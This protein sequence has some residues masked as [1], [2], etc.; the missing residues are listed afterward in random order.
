MKVLNLI[1]GFTLGAG[2]DKCF[3]TY[4]KL[5]EVDKDVEVKSFCINLLNL[6]SHIEPLKE[7]GV[8]LIDIKSRSD[9]SWI[10]RLNDLIKEEKPDV[11][12]THGFNGAIMMLLLRML[13]GMKTPVVCSYH[14]AYHAPTM[15][16][17]LVEPIYN[18][19][20]ILIYKTIA[21][22][23]ICVEN[24]SRE[25]LCKKGVRRDKVVTVHNGI[26]EIKRSVPV[27]LSKYVKAGVPTIVT[28]SRITEVKGLPYLLKALKILK[29]KGV[30]FHYF[31]I[32]EGPD[33]EA[34]KKQ[35]AEL[36]L[37]ENITFAGFQSNVPEWLAACDIFALPSLYEYH[38]IAVLEAMRAGKA[39]VA[40]TV[41]GNGESITDGFEGVLVPSKDAKA[42]C[43]GLEKM[44][45]NEDVRHQFGSLARKR[46]EKEFTE[47]AMMRNLVKAIK[48]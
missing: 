2:I 41:G 29:G 5:G 43:E 4:A 7:I 20:S 42:F 39:I 27:D 45:T 12:F 16:K 46:F 9:V 32:G 31:M 10:G 28:A 22:R 25:Y 15:S 11:V 13:K 19:L 47:E 48:G 18:G 36:G 40:T 30:D 3:M 44:L 24:V 6:N 38:S 17:K 35:S 8:T 33:L 21:K 34:Q 23:V 14:G 1:W 26:Q 37:N